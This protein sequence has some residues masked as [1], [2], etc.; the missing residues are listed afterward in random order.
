MS[1]KIS[2]IWVTLHPPYSKANSA[3]WQTF[4]YYYRQFKA[5]RQFDVKLVALCE[6]ADQKEIELENQ[7]NDCKFIY[8]DDPSVSK[9][10]KLAN[11]ESSFNPYNRHAGLMSNYLTTKILERLKEYKIE[12]VCPDFVILEWTHIVVLAN[13]IKHI[14]P[15]TKLVASEHDVTYVGY[16]RKRDYYKGIKKFNWKLRTKW[17]KKIELDALKSCSLILPHNPDNL[18]LLIKEGISQDCLQ[19]LCPYFNKMASCYRVPNGRD[20]LFFGAMSRPENY[21]SAIWFIEKVIP[22]ISDLNVRFVVLG[23][24]PADELKKYQNDRIIITGF[25]DSIIPYFESA[26][27]LVAPLVLGAGI[28]VKILEGLSSGIPVITNNIGIE[29]IP[30]K[31]GVEYIHAMEPKEYEVAIRKAVSGGVEHIGLAGKEFIQRNY[32]LTKSFEDYR[33]TLS[34]I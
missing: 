31:D 9:L 22:L 32:D 17:E 5:D 18:E 3:G 11:I 29:G 14:F 27:C 34:S 15:D 1:E 33:T 19:W 4:N 2:I 10:S 30:A 7:N 20:I 13:D 25:V 6:K 26:T 23:S 8:R 16:E 24:N 12:G 21:L 28:K